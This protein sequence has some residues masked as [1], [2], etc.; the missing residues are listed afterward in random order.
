[1]NVR[2]GALVAPAL[3]AAVLARP[4]AADGGTCDYYKWN[5]EARQYE[6]VGFYDEHEY[7]HVYGAIRGRDYDCKYCVPLLAPP[8]DLDSFAEL[9]EDFGAVGQ[10][11]DPVATPAGRTVSDLSAQVVQGVDDVTRSVAGDV[12]QLGEA[13]DISMDPWGNGG[14]GCPAVPPAA[15]SFGLYA[16]ESR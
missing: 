13:V 11:V 15:G 14:S 5:R 6:R 7:E 4:A 10:V 9:A 1:M 2:R 16:V 3:L 8:R 12:G